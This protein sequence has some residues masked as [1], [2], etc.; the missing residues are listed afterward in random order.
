MILWDKSKDARLREERGISFEDVVENIA[1]GHV[2][3]IL[4]HSTRRNQ[5]IFVI[6]LKGRLHAV[7]FLSDD[8]GKIVLKTIYPSRKLERRYGKKEWQNQT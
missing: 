1:S 6:V 5:K 7:P 4:E 2:L 8:E 3:D